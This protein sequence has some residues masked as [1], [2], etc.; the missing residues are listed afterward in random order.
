MTL[1]LFRGGTDKEY[2][3]EDKSLTIRSEEGIGLVVVLFVLILLTALGI[4]LLFSTE[5]ERAIS[6]NYS[7]SI[8][9]E[10]CAEAGVHAAIEALRYDLGHDVNGWKNQYFA[11][12]TPSNPSAPGVGQDTTGSLTGRRNQWYVD[13][14]YNGGGPAKP[15]PF[16]TPTLLHADL[17][18]ALPWAF[19]SYAGG[20][21][22]EYR[23]AFRN[24]SDDI[25]P[26]TPKKAHIYVTGVGRSKMK[27]R[28][29]ISRVPATESQ[30]AIEMKIYGNMLNIWKNAFVGGNPNAPVVAGDY[31]VHGSVLQFNSAPTQTVMDFAHDYTGVF[32]NYEGWDNLSKIDYFWLGYKNQLL[33][34]SYN[35]LRA[36][37]ASPPTCTAANY[38]GPFAWCRYSTP[39]VPALP[40][41]AGGEETLRAEVRVKAGIVYLR[42]N[43]SYLGRPEVV[44]NG[45]ADALE[46]IY[47]PGPPADSPPTPFENVILAQSPATAANNVNNYTGGFDFSGVADFVYPDLNAPMRDDTTGIYY[48]SYKQYIHNDNVSNPALQNQKPGI[49]ALDLS[50]IG[51]S[52]DMSA[53]ANSG[54]VTNITGV[55]PR[56]V[57]PTGTP[58]LSTGYTIRIPVPS[59]Q[60]FYWRKRQLYYQAANPDY[61]QCVGP[62]VANGTG[63]G[64]SPAVRDMGGCTQDYQ[65][66][67]STLLSE[68]TDNIVD[69]LWP[70]T[71]FWR[72]SGTQLPGPVCTGAPANPPYPFSNWAGEIRTQIDTLIGQA[73]QQEIAA[74]EAS[75]GTV[76]RPN[77]YGMHFDALSSKRDNTE[78]YPHVVLPFPPATYS[79]L[80]TNTVWPLSNLTYPN[81]FTNPPITASLN[82]SPPSG[83]GFETMAWAMI[84]DLAKKQAGGTSQLFQNNIAN[85]PTVYKDNG[86]AI[87][88]LFH[89]PYWEKVKPK[90][91][92][93][94]VTFPY[95]RYSLLLD[96]ESKSPYHPVKSTD[97]NALAEQYATRRRDR[98]VGAK[99]DKNWDG[100]FRV[101]RGTGADPELTMANYPS[102]PPCDPDDPTSGSA[103]N[104]DYINDLVGYQYTAN[105]DFV[106]EIA[107]DIFLPKN[108][109][110]RHITGL[111]NTTPPTGPLQPYSN[112][113]NSGAGGTH[114]EEDTNCSSIGSSLNAAS[115]LYNCPDN[116]DGLR[117]RV[118]LRTKVNTGIAADF[119]KRY[120]A[121]APTGMF[122]VSLDVPGQEK[123]GST[124]VPF[125][126]PDW[127]DTYSESTGKD[128]YYRH[129]IAYS[130]PDV[131]FKRCVDP[132]TRCGPETAAT[133][134]PPFIPWFRENDVATPSNDDMLNC[135]M[136][137]FCYHFNH[138]MFYSLAWPDDWVTGGDP[139]VNPTDFWVFGGRDQR[140]ASGFNAGWES[141]PCTTDPQHDCDMLGGQVCNWLGQR[142]VTGDASSDNEREDGF[143]ELLG[144]ATPADQ[145]AQ[146][147]G[148][149][150]RNIPARN[151]NSPCGGYSSLKG[152]GVTMTS[153]GGITFGAPQ[154]SAGY[155]V[156]PG[157]A[158][159]MATPDTAQ[160]APV[161]IDGRILLVSYND[162]TDTFDDSTSESDY[163]AG[164]D[165]GFRF[166]KN[167][168]RTTSG[169]VVFYD[170]VIPTQEFGCS[171]FGGV[172]AYKG[173]LANFGGE[174]YIRSS[175][176]SDADTSLLPVIPVIAGYSLSTDLLKVDVRSTSAVV[177]GASLA[178]SWIANQ[179]DFGTVSAGQKPTELIGVPSVSDEPACN[180]PYLP[181]R[182]SYSVTKK[183]SFAEVDVIPSN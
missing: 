124:N 26:F 1:R 123:T 19:K 183:L 20:D 96:S 3:M 77:F 169:N 97:D 57:L 168:Y 73:F 129:T 162:S 10:F 100:V 110:N 79:D 42:A 178:G 61:P 31:K 104:D 40:L 64:L 157:T 72:D 174:T 130:P 161:V 14:T 47:G 30:R 179:A 148:G 91:W 108:V 141:I 172:V 93:T 46:G 9:A 35:R 16:T 182:K 136:L 48:A 68:P 116:V 99:I 171:D 17:A 86:L 87:Y 38:P 119:W 23:L 156:Y 105:W 158:P 82:P 12:P 177:K 170:H 140:W 13:L 59:P 134:D 151:L 7:Y 29:A 21:P 103:C 131:R 56:C 58:S 33:S 142:Y 5:T 114:S 41:T 52:A 65:K 63:S 18:Q 28:T 98:W 145:P 44:G 69:T 24:A 127:W 181:A 88:V 84:T 70:S 80:P 95:Q 92:K 122:A 175:I 147:G 90:D 66:G 139:D 159:S 132:F 62:S 160:T 115:P 125:K 144:A 146:P 163:S 27:V 106:L 22:V 54:A 180:H 85:A 166:G 81:W 43:L 36:A 126:K 133:L 53:A 32:N 67:I 55:L 167:P 76:T 45:Y 111:P 128:Y 113:C 78:R 102:G 118:V 15:F 137:P 4:T 153:K 39:K 74:L 11:I 143:A 155:L 83:A 165:A 109:D 112:C 75:F 25:V 154:T 152:A 121:N 149:L 49:W 120:V 2:D 176:P 138:M 51:S 60:R 101:I 94:G 135:E 37:P 50:G 71:L 173:T 8:Q 150:Q 107:K 6:R 117:L 164:L 34:P 89:L